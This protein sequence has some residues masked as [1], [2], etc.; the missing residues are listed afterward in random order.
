MSDL[1][2]PSEIVDEFQ[3]K[4]SGFGVPI[5]VLLL[6]IITVLSTGIYFIYNKKA[7]EIESST[8]TSTTT[9]TT[10][11][12]PI[13]PPPPP[14]VVDPPP[15]DSKTDDSAVAGLNATAIAGIAL[16][17][18]AIIIIVAWMILKQKQY[19]DKH[20]EWD[21]PGFFLT[22]WISKKMKKLPFFKQV[23]KVKF[24]LNES[25]HYVPEHTIY[26]NADELLG[27]LA[28]HNIAIKKSP[29]EV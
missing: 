6:L 2:R 22:H 13:D 8:S 28:F 23:T 14:P 19:E 5:M 29:S 17:S 25:G 21:N 12:P 7:K 1:S 26:E 10:T 9:T 16:G 4:V 15:P 27:P 18:I 3:N 20:P 11:L 24:N